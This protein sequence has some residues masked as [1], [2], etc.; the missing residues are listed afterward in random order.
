[1]ST[2]RSL[3]FIMTDHQRHDSLGMTQAGVE[4][5]PAL[6]RLA[7][8][9]VRF[10]RAYNA[11]PLCAPARTALA[12]GL[13]PTANG[14]VTNDWRGERAG[15]HT[16]IHEAL[17]NAGYDVAHIGVDHIRVRPSLRERVR[18]ALWNDNGSY[19]RYAQENALDNP[20]PGGRERYK[21][22]SIENHGGKPVERAYS[23]AQ[24]G[25]FPYEARHF[26]DAYWGRQAEAFLREPRERPF[27]LFLYLWASHPPLV[28][29]EPY[30]SMFN[31]REIQLPENVGVPAIGEPLNRRRGIAARMAEGVS[32]DAWRRAWAAHLGLVRLAD[33][34][35]GGVLNALDE[36]GHADEAAV[37]FMSD[38]GDHL[39]QHAMYQKMEMYEQAVRVPFLVKV[40]GQTPRAVEEVVSHL[41]I[42]PT[43]LEAA[44]LPIP[45]GLDGR[46]LWGCVQRGETLDAQPAYICYSGNPAI[47]DIRRAVVSGRWKYVYDPDDIP[48]LYD[49]QN[50]PLETQNRAGDPSAGGVLDDLHAPLKEWGEAC[51]DWIDF[52]QTNKTA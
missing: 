16:P 24:T 11:A 34:A 18:F 37:F 32:L 22:H 29:P 7:A 23:N 46:S 2:R 12:T 50:D 1:M 45:N 28:L 52:N 4:A 48:E 19:K 25:V 31:P 38:H 41:D 10:T 6:N 40:P 8:E 35:I 3:L 51:G 39:G 44:G 21:S 20:Y 36:S 43:L 42:M 13:Y 15:D 5:V 47:G 9:S 49:L 17:Y 27:A 33:D 14:I 26:K 30:A